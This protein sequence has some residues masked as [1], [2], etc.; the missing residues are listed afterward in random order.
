[1][2]IKITNVGGLD[3]RL[4]QIET[5]AKEGLE[6]KLSGKLIS[7]LGEELPKKLA[8]AISD[9][10]VEGMIK[11]QKM[12]GDTLEE[13]VKN[14]TEC[15][16]PLVISEMKE[17][18]GGKLDE[19]GLAHAAKSLD[20]LKVK[21]T[22]EWGKLTDESKKDYRNMVNFARESVKDAIR[23]TV[24]TTMDKFYDDWK[25]LIEKLKSKG[26]KCIK[27][28]NTW[29]Q[30][31]PTYFGVNMSFESPFGYV[32]EI[33]MHTPEDKKVWHE[34]HEM[35]E[36]GRTATATRFQKDISAA[37]QKMVIKQHHLDKN[38]PNGIEKVTLENAEKL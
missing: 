13:I 34:T 32:I 26:Y 30:K 20:S 22:R 6:K 25:T 9:T 28:N 23:F 4:L 33:Q 21:V 15:V 38:R 16:V 3:A 24:N 14:Y 7:E 17:Y 29:L 18:L 11:K 36:A 10:T 8:K 35:Y 27:I 12:A 37:A 1:M 31:S 5:K 2:A 19:G